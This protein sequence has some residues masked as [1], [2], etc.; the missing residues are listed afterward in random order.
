M[1]ILT[2][3]TTFCGPLMTAFNLAPLVTSSPVSAFNNRATVSGPMSEFWRATY[4][5]HGAR[6]GTPAVP[7]WRDTSAF[8]MSLRGGISTVRLFD[9]RRYP[10]RGAGS[11]SGLAALDDNYPA[12]ATSIRLKGLTASQLVAV[13]AD[14]HFGIGEN[15]Y[16]AIANSGSDGGGEATISFLPPLRA[17]VAENDSV[18]FVKPTAVFMFMGGYD[19]GVPHYGT[20]P[21]QSLEFFEQ[22]EFDA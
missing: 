16:T 10:M 21:S 18:N 7:G 2:P 5:L 20:M 3:P 22:P 6:A 19:A 8:I 14:D 12:G 17:G 13:A 11:L 4:T 9:P 15:L 1:A